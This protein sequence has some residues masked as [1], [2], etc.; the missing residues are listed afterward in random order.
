MH[1]SV[2]FLI[3]LAVVTLPMVFGGYLAR[4]FRMPDHGWK[5]G[6]VL[7]SLL[8]GIAIVA[9]GG[10]PKLGIDLSGGVILVY[11]VDQ[12]QRKSDEPVD[13][14][15]LIDAVTRRIN[16]GGVR[17]VTIRPYGLN[18]IEIIVPE[19]DQSEMQRMKKVLTSVGLLE[20]RILANTRDHAAL[21]KRA[22][23]ENT[24][25]I[26]GADAEGKQV[27]LGRWVPIEKGQEASFN[28]PEVAKRTRK[29]GQRE[30]TEILV[31]KDDFNVT[32]GYLTQT[33]PVGRQPGPPLRELHVRRG[34]GP[35][36]RR[37]HQHEPA[38]H[39]RRT[40][41]GSWA[42]SSTASSIRRRPFKARSTT[43]A[44]SPARSPSKRCRTWS[45]CSTPAA[46]R[47]P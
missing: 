17:E 3:A 24:K 42:S 4:R 14:D 31:V 33:R 23:L 34:R 36:V 11:E 37:A 20:F 29:V 13:M 27:E 40:S 44:K 5:I 25:I 46:C 1:W 9:V 15:K 6:L 7:F 22:E 26:M 38:R 8:A 47:P 21:I 10:K 2:Y 19:A 28:Y 18:Q 45:T 32:G 41:R 39:R 30:V 43:A 16:P 12:E 35:A